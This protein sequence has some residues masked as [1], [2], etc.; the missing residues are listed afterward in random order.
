MHK[1]YK[2]VRITSGVNSKGE[3]ILPEQIDDYVSKDLKKDWYVSTYFYT[4]EHKKRFYEKIKN[5]KTNKPDKRGCKGIIDVVTNKLWFDFDS[6][7]DLHKSQRDVVAVINRLSEDQDINIDDMEIYFSGNKGFNLVLNLNRFIDPKTTYELANKYAGDLETFDS[8]LYDAPQ[9]LRVPGTI[10]QASGLYKIPLTYDQLGYEVQQIKEMATSLDNIKEEFNWPIINPL[11]S[12]FKLLIKKENKPLV[13]PKQENDLDFTQKP[14][15]WRNCKWSLFQG[16]FESGERHNALMV[17]AA[18]CRGLGYDKTTTYHMCKAAIEKQAERSGQDKFPK[19]ELYTNIIEDSIFTDGWEGG[20]YTC[21]KSGW[22]QNYCQNLGDNCCKDKDDNDYSFLTLSE[23][24]IKFKDYANNFE[25]NIIKFGLKEFDDNVLLSTSTINGLLGA[26]GGGKS[27]FSIN[28]LLNTSKNKIQS[29]FLSL[30]MGLPIVFAK[31]IQKETGYS[32]LKAL[33]VYKENS[34]EKEKIQE[35]LNDKYKYVGFNFK[36]G[37]TIPDIKNIIIEQQEQT[38]NKTRLL[39][40][41]YLECLA[42]T[43][44]DNMTMNSG[45]VANRLKDL[46]NELDICILMLLQTQKHATADVSEP[47]LNVRNIKGSSLVEQC[48]STAIT[49]WRPGYHPKYTENDKFLSMAVVKNRFGNLSTMDL[50]WN[51]LRGDI[52]SLTDEEYQ[53]LDELLE[54]KRQDKLHAL[55]NSGWE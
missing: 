55:K 34:K 38:G 21:Q 8:S 52:R 42:G 22:L 37:L 19:E 27:S 54:K 10:N 53:E 28:Y 45:L 20:Q 46:A 23:I 18:T 47:L 6:K 25:N 13:V 51:G 4:E 43:D 9:I 39:V 11:D 26:T 48:L 41:D 24:E 29:Q 7:D 14:R 35:I 2:Y 36:S 15:G 49:L 12:F 40:I 17:V 31:L 1:T 30:D 50:A 3:L 5:P 16:N 33:K 44:S 32:Y